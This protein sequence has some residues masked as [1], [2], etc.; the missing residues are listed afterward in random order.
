ML[1][2]KFGGASVKDAKAVRQLNNIVQNS[3]EYLLIVISLCVVVLN[4]WCYRG[5]VT[6]YVGLSTCFNDLHSI[7]LYNNIRITGGLR[8]QM[9]PTY[10]ILGLSNKCYFFRLFHNV[11]FHG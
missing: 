10:V 7:Y 1:V 2:Y 9:I 5:Y 4:A 3:S 6:R 8:D 11:V